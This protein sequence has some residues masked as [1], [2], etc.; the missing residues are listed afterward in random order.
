MATVLVEVLVVMPDGTTR[1]PATGDVDPSAS[2][3]EIRDAVVK[4][5]RLDNPSS[6]VMAVEPSDG[7]APVTGYTL[8]NGDRLY[9]LNRSVH[10]PPFKLKE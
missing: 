3:A 6:W 2:W 1:P 10:R 7:S 5:L 4:A 8:R 9:L